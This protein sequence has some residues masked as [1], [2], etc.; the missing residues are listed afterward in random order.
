L[1]IA[2]SIRKG[3]RQ[4]VVASTASSSEKPSSLVN[5]QTL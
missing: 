4:R 5:W 1:R 3:T 2:K